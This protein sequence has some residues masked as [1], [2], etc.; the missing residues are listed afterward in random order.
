[1]ATAFQSDSFQNDSFQIEAGPA[2]TGGIGSK[3]WAAE[4]GRRRGEGLRLRYENEEEFLL[5]LNKLYLSTIKA[6]GI[7]GKQFVNS[8]SLTIANRKAFTWNAIKQAKL[9]LFREGLLSV[10]LGLHKVNQTTLAATVQKHK[11][12]KTMRKLLEA[13]IIDKLLEEDKE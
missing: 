6:D 12:L 4:R 3:F 7:L 13:L 1:M 5:R 2:P 10:N 11:P 9:T 8:A